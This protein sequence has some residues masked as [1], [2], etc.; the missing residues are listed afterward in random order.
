ME[1]DKSQKKH[2]R[3]KNTREGAMFPRMPGSPGAIAI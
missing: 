3:K 1:R 2:D